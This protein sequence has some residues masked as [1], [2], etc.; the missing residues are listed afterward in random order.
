MKKYIALAAMCFI[1]CASSPQPV[2]A[3]VDSV[4][5]LG[6][7]CN[8]TGRSLCFRAEGCSLSVPSIGACTDKFMRICCGN[9][10]ICDEVTGISLSKVK[11]CGAAIRVMSCDS[12]RSLSKT[13]DKQYLPSECE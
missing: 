4:A 2:T 8:E 13:G 9:K 6:E 12:L 5:S 1:G 3:P 7:V 10:G 11:S